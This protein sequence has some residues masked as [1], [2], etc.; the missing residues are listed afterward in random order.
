[1]YCSWDGPGEAPACAGHHYETGLISQAHNAGVEVYPSIGGWTLSDPFPALA[2]NSAAR[3]KFAENCVKL[4]ETYDFDG[5]MLML[6]L[7]VLFIYC[8]SNLICV[9]R[10]YYPGIDI[11]WEVSFCPK[12]V[13]N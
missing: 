1:M 9:C 7:Y 12:I 5:E 4:I 13:Q 11:D 3:Q 6:G 10:S 8:S 2:A